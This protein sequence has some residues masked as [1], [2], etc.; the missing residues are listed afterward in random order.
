MQ[1][2]LN[3]PFEFIFFI[4]TLKLI[5][6][7]STYLSLKF[8]IAK[9]IKISRIRN[10]QPMQSAALLSIHA[11]GH[12]KYNFIIFALY[13]KKKKKDCIYYFNIFFRSVML[14]LNKLAQQVR[15]TYAHI[16]VN[17]VGRLHAHVRVCMMLRWDL[18]TICI[19]PNVNVLCVSGDI[20]AFINVR[21]V[22]ETISYEKLHP[23]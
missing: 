13:L 12:I 14:G 2:V 19:W 21:S 20:N 3:K 11:R 6:I 8:I 22:R 15:T 5:I 9:A 16:F 10:C 17:I 18:L 7:I 4:Y 23:F 1:S